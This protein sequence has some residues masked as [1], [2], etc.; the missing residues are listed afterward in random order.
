MRARYPRWDAVARAPV[1]SLERAIAIGGLAATKAPRIK[2]ILRAVRAR[3]G[4]YDLSR[5]ATMPDDEV[6]AYLT[7]L[8]GIGAKTAACVLAFS[9]GRPVLPVDTHVARIAVRLGLADPRAPA[10]AIQRTLEDLLA[11][12]ARVPAHLDLIA[13]GRATCRA[14][15]PLCEACPV[16]D[17]CPS[18][19]TA[20]VP[21]PSKRSR[22]DGT[23]GR[24]W[25]VGSDGARS[26]PP[27]S[28]GRRSPSVR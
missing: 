18:A 19:G 5:L 27:R 1:R 16:A 15:R 7:A 23:G 25:D 26:A 13:H 22:P 11:P 24:R 21:P 3:E 8:P 9:L 4:G 6:V 14:Q 20:S 12:A 17:L 28:S 10:D 2:E